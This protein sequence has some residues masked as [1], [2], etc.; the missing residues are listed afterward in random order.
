MAHK[1]LWHAMTNI[2]AINSRHTKK[3]WCH[4]KSWITMKF[5]DNLLPNSMPCHHH[6]EN[7]VII[8]HKGQQY[9]KL[10]NK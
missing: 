7:Q 6:I 5:C 8:N 4:K 2:G 1:T 9:F 10:A 3:L